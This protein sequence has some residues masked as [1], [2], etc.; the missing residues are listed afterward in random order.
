L[1]RL[2]NAF[3]LL[4]ACLLLLELA[5]RVAT[6]M[7]EGRVPAFY[8]RNYL[9]ALL[10]F[11]EV[12]VWAG[13][14]GAR[15]VIENPLGEKIT[16]RINEN[17]WR[18]RDF[19]PLTKPGNALIFGDSFSFGLGVRE[20]DRFAEQLEERLQ[21]VNVWAFAHMGYAPDQYGLL[22]LRWL[23]AFPWAFLVIQLS[24]N[25]VQD[26][27][28][29]SWGYVGGSGLPAT[30]SPPASYFFFSGFS[31]AWD[32]LM[33]IAVSG[34][35]PERELREGL[36]RLLLSLEKN[37]LLA[38]E[39]KIP[40]YLVQASD[41]GEPAYGKEIAEEYKS[42]VTVLAAKFGA[43][44]LEANEDFASE[45]LPAPDF[46]WTAATHARVADALFQRVKELPSFRASPPAEA[47]KK[48]RGGASGK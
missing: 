30:I 47:H 3:F 26:I 35:L 4:V 33:S 22:G 42:G 7:L 44:L 23:T 13:R 16:Y 40:V 28:Q 39:R 25:D 19:T 36:S 5:A 20:S 31:R 45:L 18:G 29:H 24:N 37:L 46:H 38:N 32:L 6:P 12:F 9:S 1:R 10:D 41:W 21:G 34:K 11:D 17:G 2:R 15:V 43:E 27:A 14:P 48:P 8:Y